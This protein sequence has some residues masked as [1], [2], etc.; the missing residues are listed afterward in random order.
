MTAHHISI[1]HAFALAALLLAGS[2]AHA[3]ERVVALSPVEKEKLL[4]A[5]AE[6][7]RPVGEELP[8]NGLGRQIHGE[9]G[10]FIGT[11]GARGVFASTVAPIGEK[12]QIALTFENSRFGR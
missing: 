7:P 2:I 1:R 12:G 11:G 6:R 4:N 3:E 9:V 5:A 10:M 8:V